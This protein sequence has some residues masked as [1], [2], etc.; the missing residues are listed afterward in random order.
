VGLDKPEIL[1]GKY[2]F[3]I[4]SCHLGRLRI[5]MCTQVDIFSKLA[6]AIEEG[7]PA[8]DAPSQ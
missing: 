4:T 2:S 8:S 7:T 3:A 1:E 6:E 5:F